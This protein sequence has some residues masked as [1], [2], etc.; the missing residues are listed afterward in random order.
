MLSD[1]SKTCRLMLMA[2]A[3]MKKMKVKQPAHIVNNQLTILLS[4]DRMLKTSEHLFLKCGKSL[5]RQRNALTPND[6][7]HGETMGVVFRHFK[8]AR[9]D[10]H[11]KDSIAKPETSVAA[12]DCSTKN[13]VPVNLCKTK[14]VQPCECKVVCAKKRIQFCKG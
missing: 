6:Q 10:K 12:E 5:L 3:P 4:Q 13:I 9:A 14:R 2:K 8:D 7:E 11:A 1:R